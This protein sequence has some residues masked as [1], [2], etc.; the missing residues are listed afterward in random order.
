MAG[1]VLEAQTVNGVEHNLIRLGRGSYTVKA[2]DEQGKLVNY[3]I[4][5]T[6]TRAKKAFDNQVV[7]A[8]ASPRIAAVLNKFRQES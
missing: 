2:T 7:H 8:L 6:V 5:S 3:R 1:T 4:Y